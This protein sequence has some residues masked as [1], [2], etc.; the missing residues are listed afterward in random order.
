[1]PYAIFPEFDWDS[2]N[3]N[4]NDCG[5]GSCKYCQWFEGKKKM[6][7]KKAYTGQSKSQDVMSQD[8]YNII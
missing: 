6:T 5:V 8:L 3:D 2:D 7:F 4:D 1:M